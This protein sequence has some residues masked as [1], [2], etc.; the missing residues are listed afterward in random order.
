MLLLRYEDAEPFSI[1]HKHTVAT[2]LKVIALPIIL[3]TADV[4]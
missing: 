3:I 1:I 4:D 2:T